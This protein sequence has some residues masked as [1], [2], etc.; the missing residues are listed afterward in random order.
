MESAEIILL[1]TG[2]VALLYLLFAILL[3]YHPVIDQWLMIRIA[4][5]ERSVATKA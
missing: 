2:C 5:A 1:S 4:A 3:Y